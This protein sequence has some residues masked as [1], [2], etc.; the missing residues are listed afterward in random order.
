MPAVISSSVADNQTRGEPGAGT[1]PYLGSQACLG[2][3]GSPHQGTT[4]CRTLEDSGVIG[5]SRCP[6]ILGSSG[7]LRETSG[8]RVMAL[9]GALIGQWQT[10]CVTNLG[11][12]EPEST[13]Q[14]VVSTGGA[15]LSL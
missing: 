3:V 12:M 9:E 4:A 2:D 8:L 15:T 14:V 13:R 5:V 11:Q 1:S 6:G 7:F 10:L